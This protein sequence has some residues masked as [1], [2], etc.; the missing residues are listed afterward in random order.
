M[1]IN[2]A[3]HNQDILDTPF[4]IVIYTTEII[5]IHR[6]KLSIIV[7]IKSIRIFKCIFFKLIINKS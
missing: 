2:N 1:R 7:I 3:N 6:N 4:K 5:K